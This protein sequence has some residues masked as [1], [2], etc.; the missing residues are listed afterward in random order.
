MSKQLIRRRGIFI[1]ILIAGLLGLR[2]VSFCSELSWLE[3][4]KNKARQKVALARESKTFIVM[5]N[6]FIQEGGM[7]ET[8][9]LL[10]KHPGKA[11]LDVVNL[12][13]HEM[14]TF[15]VNNSEA[16]FNLKFIPIEIF[17]SQLIPVLAGESQ[18]GQILEDESK[19]HVINGLQNFAIS[20][21]FDKIKV[22]GYLNNDFFSWNKIEIYCLGEEWIKYAELYYLATK[23]VAGIIYPAEARLIIYRPNGTKLSRDLRISSVQVD[24]DLEDK[25]FEIPQGQ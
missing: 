12:E 21:L 19:A 13:T 4:I 1:L 25:I 23:D 17:V 18:F 24:T 10:I 6:V 7:V 16:W 3:D 14:S 9:S 20:F 8:R 11:R 15:I 5:T 22:I 2:S